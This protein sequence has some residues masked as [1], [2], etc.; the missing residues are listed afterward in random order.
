MEP[1]IVSTA[2]SKI[3]FFTTLH[4]DYKSVLKRVS[5]ACLLLW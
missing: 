1:S 2:L 5:K 3:F 4:S